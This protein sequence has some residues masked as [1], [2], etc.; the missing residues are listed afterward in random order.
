MPIATTTALL[1]LTAASAG[2]Q[3]VGSLRQGGAAKR[4]ANY[5][6]GL[7]DI[8]A[9]IAGLQ[10]DDALARGREAASKVRGDTRQL[11]GTQ[12]TAAAAS[13]VD[14]STGSAAD[15]Q[16]DTSYL[17]ELDAQTILNNARREAWGLEV[18]AMNA[19]ATGRLTRMA[20]RNAAAAGRIGAT[21]SLLTG[22][23]QIL[24]ARSRTS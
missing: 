5:E 17:G 7:A 10:A 21:N 15:V 2:S 11:L 6:A 22:G 8:N 12:R 23:A 20:G 24:S 9:T 13:G 18:D 19:R 1:A 3:A 14:I 4:Q 16:R